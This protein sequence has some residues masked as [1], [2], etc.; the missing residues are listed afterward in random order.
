M[1]YSKSWKVDD[2]N[3]TTKDYAWWKERVLDTDFVILLRDEEFHR[4]GFVVFSFHASNP[5]LR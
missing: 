4:A 3:Y 1:S 2:N 5:I